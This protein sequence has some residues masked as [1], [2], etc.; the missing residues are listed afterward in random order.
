[1]YQGNGRRVLQST[2]ALAARANRLLQTLERFRARF[3]EVSAS[4]LSA[5]IEDLV[6]VQDVATVLQRAEMVIRVACEISECLI[7]LG[8]NGRLLHLQLNELTNGVV[9][10][11]RLV[12]DDYLRPPAERDP[13]A[14]I[15]ALAEL[16]TDD[17]LDLER[18]AATFTGTAGEGV[19]LDANVEP[20]GLRL[21]ARVPRVS[22]EMAGRIV[23]HFND[24]HR[25]LRAPVSELAE[26]TGIGE[27]QAKAVKDGVARL[28]EASILD[29]FA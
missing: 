19:D 24:L 4:L 23:A 12:L 15:A 29:R 25:V 1:V 20:R 7:E 28:A 5:E 6:T 17:L 18:V 2:N 13:G 3:D 26:V 9:E 27:D 21:L 22:G 10:E 11:R 14:V 8:D 16:A